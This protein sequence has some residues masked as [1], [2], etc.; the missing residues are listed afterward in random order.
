MKPWQRKYQRD[1]EKRLA[2]AWRID[3]ARS[4]CQLLLWYKERHPEACI[5]AENASYALDALDRGRVWRLS[6]NRA[7]DGFKMET[8]SGYLKQY[9]SITTHGLPPVPTS[10]EEETI[11]GDL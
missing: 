1:I 6:I 5:N 10:Y 2:G 9:F 7:G 3:W 11:C 4:L 8:S